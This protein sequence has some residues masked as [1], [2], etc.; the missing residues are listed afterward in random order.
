MELKG[1]TTEAQ[2]TQMAGKDYLG[3]IGSL[4]YVVTMTRPDCMFHVSYLSQFMSNPTTACYEA[5][6]TV[7]S[8]LNKTRAMGLTY[9]GA[10]KDFIVEA[11]PQ[12]D[13]EQRKAEHGLLVW[14]D[15]S[16][17]SHKSH[18][19]HAICL[20]NSVVVWSSRRLKVIAMSSTEAEMC[21]G[22]GAAKDITFIR[23]VLTFLKFRLLG[24]TPLI[25]D[26]EGMW[27]SVRNNVT[28]AR[29][30]Y[31]ELWQRFVQDCHVRC[32]LSI[33][34]CLTSDER[35]DILTKAMAKD[36]RLF[37]PFRDELM[38]A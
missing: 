6:L 37:A 12:I 28:S 8:Y 13:L 1:A 15:A 14:S 26:N 20:A 22:V 24:P 7:L 27:H 9:G 38:N 10:L 31:F 2:K 18:G 36:E 25:I 23:E 17:G 30:R 33:H 21:A 16:W 5:A 4:L 35:A 34:L 19:G 29:T 32:R 3:L 11:N